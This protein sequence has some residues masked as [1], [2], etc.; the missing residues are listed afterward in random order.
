M[1]SGASM[2]SD[3]D[4]TCRDDFVFSST[5]GMGGF[6]TVQSTMHVPSKTWM[7]LKATNIKGICKHKKG[8]SMLAT[9]VR[10]LAHLSTSE[11][12]FLVK[13]H[14]AFR[15]NQ[16]CYVALDLHT[17][18]DLRYHIR[19]KRVF[20][21]KTSAFFAICLSSAL[22]FIHGKGILHRDIKPENVIL[23]SLGFPYL[24]DFGVSTIS[25]PCEELQCTGS[26]G[27]RQYLAPEVFTVSHR[28]G[29]EADFWSLGV[30]LFEL[31]YGRRPFNKH[32]YTDMIRFHEDLQSCGVALS[33]T[34]SR[35]INCNI[36]SSCSGDFSPEWISVYMG[37]PKP[38]EG[39]CC[40]EK[41]HWLHVATTIKQS[42]I[43]SKKIEY[44]HRN[45]SED[46]KVD[47]QNDNNTLT[48]AHSK[49]NCN[50]SEVSFPARQGLP[51]FLRVSMPKYSQNSKRVSLACMSV[52]EGL[53][54]IR[55]WSR[56]GAGNNYSTLKN[57]VW[58]DEWKLNWEDVEQGRVMSPYVPNVAKVTRDLAYKHDQDKY[59]MSPHSHIPCTT[60]VIEKNYNKM[61]FNLPTSDRNILQNFH[62]VAPQ[63][64]SSM[65][66]RTSYN[67]SKSTQSNFASDSMYTSAPPTTLH[68]E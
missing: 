43:L 61:M 54:D 56:L 24:T 53:L 48:K 62:Y 64:S 26:S 25:N 36:A 60:T 29:V 58:F 20:P 22:H 59:I 68:S 49:R 42:T 7:A 4:V 30:M 38:T 2:G 27:T 3:K 1:G 39:S 41:T 8:L 65:D 33:S 13:I 40:H 14:F 19:N 9:E 57:H 6:S 63:Y 46:A 5:I 32:C 50:K 11:Q 28:H 18:G 44:L 16:K 52:L 34:S 67:Q 37:T 31:I 55:L 15:D 21:E 45:A 35:F 12:L 23:D 10:I 66:E 51:A 47:D 17:G